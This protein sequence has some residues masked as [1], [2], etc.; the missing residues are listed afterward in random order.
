VTAA[1]FDQFFTFQQR[2]CLFDNP[3]EGKAQLVA[4]R[5]GGDLVVVID[6][7]KRQIRDKSEI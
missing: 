3:V 5:L 6:E 7:F 2:E 4:D 1:D